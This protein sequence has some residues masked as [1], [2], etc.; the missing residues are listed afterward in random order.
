MGI[1]SARPTAVL[2]A[3]LLLVAPAR[4]A[5]PSVAERYGNIQYSSA[6]G[7]TRT[8]TQD[9]NFGE[10][11]L[12]PDGRTVAFIHLDSKGDPG[13]AE[14]MATSLWIADGPSGT[15]R[16][17]VGSTSNP[18]PRLDFTSFQ[19]PIF[20]LD[21]GYVYVSADAW[22]TSPAVHQVSVAT[23]SE[24]FVIDG[25]A[26]AVIR[27]GKYRGYLLVSRHMYRPAPEYG[28]YN[29]IYVVRPDGKESFI[30][31]GS[32]QDDGEHSLDR[33]LDA[34]GYKAW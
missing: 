30:V 15:A 24:R 31:P 3:S 20:S 16:K 9:G 34:N 6:D 28:S 5:E 1:S 19:H 22:A 12:S 4:A 26:M 13:T 27:T 29:P 18:E 21:G 7:S 14:N 2:V 11:V 32:D 17:L 10:P 8:L 25:S 33:W 23:G